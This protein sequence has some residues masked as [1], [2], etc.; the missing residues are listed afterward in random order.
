MHHYHHHHHL[1]CLLFLLLLHFNDSQS[2]E[3]IPSSLS[4]P[5]SAEFISFSTQRAARAAILAEKITNMLLLGGTSSSVANEREKIFEQQRSESL[6]LLESTSSLRGP[7]KYTKAQFQ[8]VMNAGEH[9]LLSSRSSLLFQLF[10]F[11]NLVL[12]YSRTLSLFF[13]FFFFFFCLMHISF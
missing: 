6:L 13:F 8:K 12:T 11:V 10:C 5:P 3:N 7:P 1:S 9:L 2:I 4:S